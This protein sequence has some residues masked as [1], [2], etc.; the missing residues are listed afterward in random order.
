MNKEQIKNWIINGVLVIIIIT[1]LFLYPNKPYPQKL[2]NIKVIEF[3][4]FG[5]MTFKNNTQLPLD[6][7]QYVYYLRCNEEECI[8]NRFDNKKEMMFKAIKN[9]EDNIVYDKLILIKGDLK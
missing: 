2:E 5:N 4:G 1:L 6:P 3:V 9:K 7:N 8:A